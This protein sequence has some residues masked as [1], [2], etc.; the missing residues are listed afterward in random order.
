MKTIY[1]CVVTLVISILIACDAKTDKNNKDSQK[2]IME[3]Q[4]KAYEKAQG[5]EDTLLK[6]EEER[7]NEMKIQGI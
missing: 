5:V 6:A 1:I 3:N 4:V 2:M 7:K